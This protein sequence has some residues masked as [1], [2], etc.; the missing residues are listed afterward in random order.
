MGSGPGIAVGRQTPYSSSV[1]PPVPPPVVPT[2]ELSVPPVTLSVAPPVV[3]PVPPP[4]PPVPPPVV[5]LPPTLLLGAPLPPP[6]SPPQPES[7]ASITIPTQELVSLLLQSTTS[8]GRFGSTSPPG[9]F[10]P[11][12]RKWSVRH[13]GS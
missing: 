5:I 4:K 12:A 2:V 1:N 13:R 7:A 6:S 11:G 3:S 8:S 10:F 9:T